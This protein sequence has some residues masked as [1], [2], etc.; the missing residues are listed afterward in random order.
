MDP[1]IRYLNI[2]LFINKPAVVLC[3]VRKPAQIIMNHG[4]SQI[5]NERSSRFWLF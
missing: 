1:L 2:D 3:F 5:P 4:K